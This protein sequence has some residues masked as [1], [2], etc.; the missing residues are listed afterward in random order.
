M[1]KLRKAVIFSATLLLGFLN[2]L[3]FVTAVVVSTCA[4]T[5]QYYVDD[6]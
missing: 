2:L 5:P 4:S 6:F 1:A 3:H